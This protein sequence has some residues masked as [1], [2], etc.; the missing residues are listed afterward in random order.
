ML[1]VD[2]QPTGMRV[3][4]PS[5]GEQSF[6]AAVV[7]LTPAKGK[8][9]VASVGEDEA[10]LRTRIENLQRE[11]ALPGS[12]RITLADLVQAR[13]QVAAVNAGRLPRGPAAPT[14]PTPC[15]P[16]L[17]RDADRAP[18]GLSGCRPELGAVAREVGAVPM[19]LDSRHC[20]PAEIFEPGR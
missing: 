8:P 12:H 4:D 11:G 2:V 15:S 18:C 13:G 1:E 16:G 7:L 9:V 17:G 19:R 14:V 20:R 6:T 3:F 5:T 10:T